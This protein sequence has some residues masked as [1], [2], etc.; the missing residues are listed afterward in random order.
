MKFSPILAV[1]VSLSIC[2]AINLMPEKVEDESS[3]QLQSSLKKVYDY[4]FQH[5]TYVNYIRIVSDE[6]TADDLFIEDEIERSL[7]G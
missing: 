4:Y 6:P 7:K 3:E 2:L 5:M 1:F